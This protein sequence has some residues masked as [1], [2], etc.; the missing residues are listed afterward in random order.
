MLYH[1]ALSIDS[2]DYSSYFDG[3]AAAVIAVKNWQFFLPL[4]TGLSFH[5]TESVIQ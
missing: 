2:A 4:T 5:S 1:A 3:Y